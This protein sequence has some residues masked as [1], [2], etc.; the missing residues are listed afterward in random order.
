MV[1]SAVGAWSTEVRP[2]DNHLAMVSNGLATATARNLAPGRSGQIKL[3]QY[4]LNLLDPKK[5]A[6]RHSLVS[7]KLLL[8]FLGDLRGILAGQVTCFLSANH[9][10][11]L[12][13]FQIYESCGHDAVINKL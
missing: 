9:P 12:H 11:G 6:V 3:A 10:E 2:I 5:Y 8:V 4:H 13:T 1:I 7:F